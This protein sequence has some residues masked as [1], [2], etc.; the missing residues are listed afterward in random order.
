MTRDIAT[1]RRTSRQR[2]PTLLEWTPELVARFWSSVWTTRLKEFSFAR[3][4]GR[5]LIVALDHLWPPGSSVLDFGAGVGD[6]SAL[7]LERNVNVAAHD[8]SAEAR[9]MLKERFDGRTG[10][11]GIVG[12]SDE[13]RQFDVVILAE[14]I[15]HILPAEFQL[16]L[17]SAARYV[18]PGGVI[19]VTTPNNED[20]ELGMCVDPLNNVMFHRWQHVRCFDRQSLCTTLAAVGFAEVVTHELELSDH[21]FIPYDVRWGQGGELPAHLAAMRADQPCRIGG[22]QN[23]VYVGRKSG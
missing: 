20:L 16:T 4:G 8:P 11:I 21:L 19:V 1:D 5:A 14:V 9:A 2:G 13:H 15:E 7:L 23:L 3:Q 10:F 6:L 17:G 22:Q 18:R 12:P